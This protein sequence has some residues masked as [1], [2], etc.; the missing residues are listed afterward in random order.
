MINKVLE[1]KPQI[2]RHQ[3]SYIRARLMGPGNPGNE[4]ASIPSRHCH[5]SVDRA[6][7][8]PSQ[9]N[10]KWRPRQVPVL[11]RRLLERVGRA[12]SLSRF[13]QVITPMLARFMTNDRAF[14]RVRRDKSG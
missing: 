10:V 9:S 7:G 13:R 3:A 6:S 1:Q 5:Q 4:A 11:Q 12:S 8:L 2:L 14:C